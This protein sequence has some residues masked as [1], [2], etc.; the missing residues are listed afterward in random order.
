M[1][2]CNPI[3]VE[4]TKLDKTGT[5]ILQNASEPIIKLQKENY[6]KNNS[7]IAIDIDFLIT[8]ER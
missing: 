7:C 5:V 6:L 1:L 4:D 3:L 2:I 8:F